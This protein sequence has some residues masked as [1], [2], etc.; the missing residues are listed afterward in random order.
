MIIFLNS[1][2]TSSNVPTRGF[3]WTP[4]QL[5]C[6]TSYDHRLAPKLNVFKTSL[7]QASVNQSR[8]QCQDRTQPPAR[9]LLIHG[10]KCEMRNVTTQFLLSSRSPRQEG[11]CKQSNPPNLQL[12]EPKIWHPCCPSFFLLTHNPMFRTSYLLGSFHFILPS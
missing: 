3:Q 6:S 2:M 9:C 5:Q 12:L 4:S 7:G 11:Y 1:F 8:G 10:V